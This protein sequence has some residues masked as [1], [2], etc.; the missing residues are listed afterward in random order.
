MRLA[1]RRRDVRDAALGGLAAAAGLLLAARVVEGLVVEFWAAPLV[2][3][4]VAALGA[5]LEPVL[6]LAAGSLSV[7]WAL[8]LGAGAQVVLAHVALLVVPGVAAGSWGTTVAALA[9]VAVVIV[10]T[11]WLLGADDR[12]FLVADLVRRGRARGAAGEP[13]PPGLVVVQID[14]LSWQVLRH[15]LSAGETPT[16]ARWLR[17][18]T[19]EARPWWSRVPATTP[20]SQAGLL[21]GTSDGVVAFRWYDKARRRLVVT[22]RPADAAAVEA[23]LSDGHGLLAEGGVAVSTMFTGDAATSL[24]VMSRAGRRRG[25]GPGRDYLRYVGRPL[26]LARGVLLSLGEMVK[27]LAQAASQR[28]RDVRPRVPRR[29]SFV[30]LRAAT[31]VLLRDLDVALVAEHMTRGAPVVFV[32]FVDYDE[33]AHHAGVARGEALDSLSGLDSAIATLERV[34]ADC[35]REYRF[36]V[37]SDHGQSQGPTFRQLEGETLEHVVLGLV[38][39]DG[40]R[41]AAS[42]GTEEV[43][44]PVSTMLA[45]V[46]A[47]A[48]ARPRWSARGQNRPT[49]GQARGQARGGGEVGTDPRDAAVVVAASGNLGLVWFPELADRAS[50]DWVTQT[51]PALVP[52][53]LAR[54]GVGF[55]VVDSPRGPLAVGRGGVRVLADGSLEGEDPLAGLGPHAAPDLLRVATMAGAPDVLVHSDHDPRTG[56]VHAFEDLVGSHGGLG[57][58]QNRA[59]LLHPADWNLDADLLA[60]GPGGPELVGAEAVHRQL[61]RW[62]GRAGIRR[63]PARGE[64]GTGEGVGRCS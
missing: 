41:V 1:V 32:D 15:G 60:D 58:E 25:L 16:L 17:S 49:R 21:H 43:W 50:V 19:H 35:P 54:R 31:N 55:L 51:Y 23:A 62:M 4:L 59:V 24:L 28:R 6:R 10:A 9:V 27:E 30:V 39:A 13:R 64:L 57:G 38:G 48:G 61:V 56:E 44:G 33:I 2:V 42:T 29:A 22:N 3:V 46:L 20:A 63:A 36:V 45:D 52:G 8:L 47:A 5:L 37:L 26:A 18:G 7:W 14:G 12:D 11:R 34:A 40:E 53:L